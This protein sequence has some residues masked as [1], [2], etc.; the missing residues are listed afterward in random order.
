[1]LWHG[2]VESYSNDDNLELLR[3]VGL[4]GIALY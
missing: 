3:H 1:M 4:V 2:R